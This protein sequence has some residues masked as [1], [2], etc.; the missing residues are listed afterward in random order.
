VTADLRFSVPGKVFLLGEY[1]VLEGRQAVVAAVPPRFGLGI[2]RA[3]PIARSPA[4][5]LLAAAGETL[6]HRLSDPHLGTGGFG[7]STAEFALHYRSLVSESP[8]ARGWSLS[9]EAVWAKYR[10]L[11]AGE[12]LVPSGA[13]LFV[14]WSGGVVLFTPSRV[15]SSERL[16]PRS[17]LELLVL[18]AAR[19]PGRKVA[20]HEHLRDLAASPGLISAAAIALEAPCARGIAA[21]RAGDAA[22]LGRAFVEHAEAL[23]ALGLETP[24]TTQDREA[25][26]GQPGVLGIK[27][28]GALQADALVLSLD[29]AISETDRDNILSIAKSRGLERIF[30]GWPEEEGLRC[31]S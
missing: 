12:A 9:A 20:T 23:R 15:S 16:F 30:L 3:T 19:Q 21:L 17:R 28:S 8:R 13:D 6:A 7:A 14:Q 27:G 10:E 18:S 22:G 29:P 31:E 2:G 11:H 4:G 26:S 1:A 24:G 5:R 25:F